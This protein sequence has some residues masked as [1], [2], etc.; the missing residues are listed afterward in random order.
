VIK[1]H[2]SLL[3]LFAVL[4]G[5]I[6]IVSVYAQPLYFLFDLFAE[7][8]TQL[9]LF[10]AIFAG[11]CLIKRNCVA[12]IIAV[13]AVALNTQDFVKIYDNQAS[14]VE[15]IMPQPPSLRLMHFNVYAYN[16]D[17]AAVQ[18][19]IERNN[20]DVLFMV[21]ATTPLQDQLKAIN[22]Q[23]PYRFPKMGE[24][25]NQFLFFSKI[26]IVSAKIVRFPKVGNRLLHVV[27]QGK[28]GVFHFVGVHT[29]SPTNAT[30]MRDRDR[31]LGVIANYVATLKE[32]VIVAGDHNATPFAKA[33][34]DYISQSGLRN[35]QLQLLPYFSW[36]CDVPP[37]LRIPIDQVLVSPTI[38]VVD[39]KVGNCVGSDHLP[40]IV[41]VVLLPTQENF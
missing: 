6:T 35:T 1:K 18:A 40:I 15:Y 20:P 19:E 34:R 24:N 14:T 41:D 2:C 22:E 5:C 27:L 10:G 30:R 7:F 9:V 4:Y 3:S 37:F 21:E 38:G 16:T 33:F 36:S 25:W 23:Y 28:K 29:P 13:M 11:V 8:R 12:S 39:K 17:Y 32:P 26:P 31:H